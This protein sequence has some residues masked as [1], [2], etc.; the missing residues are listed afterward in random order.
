MKGRWHRWIRKLMLACWLAFAIFPIYW[1]VITAFKKQIDIYQGPKYLPFIDFRPTL[2]AWET[3]FGA[4]NFDFYHDFANSL[5]FASSSALLAVVL[6]AFAAYGL[7]QYRYKVWFYRNDDIAYLLVSQRFMPPIVAV[8]AIYIIYQ[9]L[10]L[11]DSRIGMVLVYA[12]FDLPLA[13]FLLRNFFEQI[14]V[15]LEQAAAI[16]GYGKIRRLLWVVFPL[17]APGLAAAYMIC[18]VF[19]WNDFLFALI[20]TFERATTLPIMIT[21]LNTQMQPMWWLLSAVGVVVM[22]PPVIV[23]VV[24][25]RYMQRQIFRGAV[26]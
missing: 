26:R 22:V 4:N 14:P 17:A 18:F 7:A 5:I 13:I 25:D 8:L 9:K 12:A 1:T 10:A 24:L 6:G 2:F 21:N 15:E 16:D 23:A 11:L 19:S 3:L 20:L